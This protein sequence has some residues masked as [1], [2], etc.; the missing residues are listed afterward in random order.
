[1]GLELEPHS[2]ASLFPAGFRRRT[3]ILT[4]LT[5]HLRQGEIEHAVKH[6]VMSFP[7]DA[8]DFLR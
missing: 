8:V 4:Q 5:A 6:F 7:Q 3:K 1:M 2:R